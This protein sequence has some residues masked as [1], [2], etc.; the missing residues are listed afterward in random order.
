MCYICALIIHTKNADMQKKKQPSYTFTLNPNAKKSTP[1][2]K[3][4]QAQDEPQTDGV[5][6]FQVKKNWNYHT[7][8][9]DSGF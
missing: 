3:A 2:P 8:Y 4:K 6:Y 7:G 1:T 5:E 9:P